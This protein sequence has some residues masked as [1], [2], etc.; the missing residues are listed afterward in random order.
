MEA[1]AMKRD[2]EKEVNRAVDVALGI[3]GLRIVEEPEEPIE[4]VWESTRGLCMTY[5]GFRHPCPV[6]WCRFHVYCGMRDEAVDKLSPDS[7]TCVLRM[8]CGSP[9]TLEEV[10]QSF[11]VTR[12]RIRQIEHAAL[13]RVGMG[14]VRIG[15][16]SQLEIDVE[17]LARI[18]NA[19]RRG[20]V[21]K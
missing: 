20:K 18:R 14:L 7:D 6:E 12:E 5:R 1:S 19:S 13:S 3:M 4:N 8:A 21:L 17:K 2:S 16:I 15:V 9:H 10:G 11:G